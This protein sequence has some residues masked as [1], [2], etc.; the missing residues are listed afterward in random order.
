MAGF[1]A[2]CFTPGRAGPLAREGLMRRRAF[3]E[4]LRIVLNLRTAKAPGLTIP[5]APL[6]RAAEAI[7]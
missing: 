5:P 7:E 6:V 3:I 4:M 2:L 1:A